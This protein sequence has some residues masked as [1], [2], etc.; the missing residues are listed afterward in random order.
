MVLWKKA[1]LKFSESDLAADVI[2][3]G[4]DNLSTED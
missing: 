4:V 2:D 1:L 3:L